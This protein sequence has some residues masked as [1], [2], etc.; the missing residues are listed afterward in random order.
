MAFSFIS[1]FVLS[2]FA[3]YVCTAILQH[4]RLTFV[5][6]PDATVLYIR[7]WMQ[8]VLLPSDLFSGNKAKQTVR[9]LNTTSWIV[10]T[11]YI[12]NGILQVITYSVQDWSF[13][14]SRTLLPVFLV[15]PWECCPLLCCWSTA[16]LAPCLEGRALPHSPL[17]GWPH[18]P[19][20]P[21]TFPLLHRLQLQ[22]WISQV[23]FL[24]N[25]QLMI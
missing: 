17:P 25:F 8:M 15:A 11:I 7:G 6:V 3:T 24:S 21:G 4:S 12:Q 19:Q 22:L 5:T 13:L 23:F 10:N 16:Y 1:N 20:G 18:F 2:N 9:Y 14:S